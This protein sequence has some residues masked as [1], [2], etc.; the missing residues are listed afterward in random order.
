[1]DYISSSGH[2]V[3]PESSPSAYHPLLLSL[4]STYKNPQC[5]LVSFREPL[6]FCQV[7]I[8]RANYSTFIQPQK[9][10]PLFEANLMGNP[11]VDIC[12]LLSLDLFMLPIHF[13]VYFYIPCH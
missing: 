11:D 5:H 8:F 2:N 10:T 7:I 6:I 4:P 9:N 3:K 12:A 1:M 13:G